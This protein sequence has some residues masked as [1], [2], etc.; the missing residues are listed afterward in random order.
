V[1]PRPLQLLL[2][3]TAPLVSLAR[4]PPPPPP[5][6]FAGGLGGYTG[7]GAEDGASFYKLKVRLRH[8]V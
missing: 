7:D 2:T 8:R 1:T 5:P 6:P 4:G 3:F